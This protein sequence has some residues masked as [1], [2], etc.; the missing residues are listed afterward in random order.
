MYSP[1]PQ[2]LH[3]IYNPHRIR[4]ETR[5]R[6]SCTNAENLE[7]PSMMLLKPPS[8]GVGVHRSFGTHPSTPGMAR[9]RRPAIPLFTGSGG[10]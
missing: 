1:N 4:R 2:S 9:A 7:N 3:M 5:I 10:Q 6:R 8:F